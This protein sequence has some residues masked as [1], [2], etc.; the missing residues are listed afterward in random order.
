MWKILGTSSYSPAHWVSSEKN[1]TWFAERGDNWRGF[2]EKGET[3]FM[4]FPAVP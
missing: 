1:F 4:H 3:Q 2:E